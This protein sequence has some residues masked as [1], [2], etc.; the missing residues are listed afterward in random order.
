MVATGK[1]VVVVLMAGRPLVIPWMAQNVPAIVNAS[2]LGTRAGEAIADVLTGKY[3]PSG[4]LTMSFP[5]NEGQ[6]PVYHSMKNTGR[7]LDPANKYTSKY[8]DVANE[9][10]YP[11]GFGLSYSTFVYSDLKLSSA[12][13]HPADTLTVTVKVTN[14]SPIDGEEVIQLYTRDHVGSVTRPVKEL[15]GF[16]KMVIKAGETRE[17]RFNL[18]ADDLRFYTADLTF[19]AEPG[20][21]TVMAGANSTDL[22]G[23][24]FELLSK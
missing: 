3:N 21:F 18:T 1:P 19:A 4:R 12:V 22:I 14:T 6:I 2:H 7:P 17:V 5:R 16:Q 9:P 13:M 8:L 20:W 24:K 10:L 23:E 11:F 15:K